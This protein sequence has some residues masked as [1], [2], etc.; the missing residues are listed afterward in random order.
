MFKIIPTNSLEIPASITLLLHARMRPSA[1]G[2]A[3][4]QSTGYKDQEEGRV[5]QPWQKA[6]CESQ[7]HPQAPA[8]N[9]NVSHSSNFPQH[10]PHS[11]FFKILFFKINFLSPRGRY[12]GFSKTLLTSD[13]WGCA[14]HPAQG[15]EGPARWESHPSKTMRESLG[16]FSCHVCLPL[17]LLLFQEPNQN[18]WYITMRRHMDRKTSF[19]PN[20][21][22]HSYPPQAWAHPASHR[23]RKTLMGRQRLGQDPRNKTLPRCSYWLSFVHT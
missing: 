2:K 8:P 3:H 18:P 16:R 23:L 15:K 12:R 1:K 11:T 19:S 20:S 17:L 14:L 13:T 5:W 6:Q 7:G 22:P 4:F 21:S 9:P 10:C